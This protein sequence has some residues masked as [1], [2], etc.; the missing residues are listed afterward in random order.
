MDETGKVIPGVRTRQKSKWKSNSKINYIIAVAFSI[1][2]LLS[3]FLFTVSDA[4]AS[5]N[6][7][8]RGVIVAGQNIGG[9][10]KEE[11]HKIL[12]ENSSKAIE[13]SKV[14]LKT[15]DKSTTITAADVNA[16][17]DVLSS[18]DAA[19]LYGKSN[20]IFKNIGDVF[21]AR[22]FKKN[23]PAVIKYDHIKLDELISNFSEMAGGNLKQHEVLV[24]DSQIVIKPGKSG[25]GINIKNA[26][27]AFDS[28]L[29]VAKQVEVCLDIE[30]SSPTPID[31]DELYDSV[32]REPVNSKYS[33]E[34]KNLKIV[35]HVTGRDFDKVNA[36]K[37]LAGLI[38]GGTNVVIQMQ[39]IMP[40]ITTASLSQGLF[41]DSLGRQTSKYLKSNVPRSKN[42]ELSTSFIN[43]TVLLPGEEFSYN[44]IVGPRTAQRGFRNAAIYENNR[45]VDG[46]GGGIC[47]VASTLY[48]AALYADMEITSRTCHSLEVSYIPLGVDATVVYGAIDFKFKN[49]TDYPVKINAYASGG[50]L[51]M[52][53]VGTNKNPNRSIKI[54]TSKIKS[55]PPTMKEIPDPSLPAGERVVTNNGFTGHIVDTYKLIYENGKLVENKFLHRSVYNMSP[56][57]VRVGTGAVESIVDPETIL[58]E[59]TDASPSP[60]PILSPSPTPTP[61]ISPTVSPSSIPST[62]PSLTPTPSIKPTNTPTSTPTPS[63]KPTENSDYPSGI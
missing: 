51:S 40:P 39:E 11:A 34:G 59:E 17:I 62:T 43:G 35:P 19:I 25:D 45:M 61:S 10:T 30:P 22:I 29:T 47:Q 58:P 26:K 31:I 18:V 2:L 5:K 16:K 3:L 37:Q 33:K 6:T 46:M 55:T 12:I 28:A 13:N 44:Q 63:L 41:K 14:V 48:G 54:T 36:K 23:L 49:N 56:G 24:A 32:Y 52:E 4:F 38:E 50:N 57:E 27:T 1:I 7:I 8:C 9:L 20:N 60:D 15:N 42:V 21:T 53:L